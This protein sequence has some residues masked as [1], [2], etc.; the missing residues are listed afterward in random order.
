ML[1]SAWVP[2]GRF[3]GEGRVALSLSLAPGETGEVELTVRAQ[4]PPGTLVENAFL[5][6][7]ARL[8]ETPWRIFA[9]MR[10][11]FDAKA[12]PRP[13]VESVTFQ[14]VAAAAEEEN[15]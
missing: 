3:R 11:E 14:R 1:E 12:H 8:A 15:L 9:R 10:V 7:R 5:I 4:E 6:L 13:V 2:H